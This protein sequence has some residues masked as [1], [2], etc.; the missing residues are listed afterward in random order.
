MD[1]QEDLRAAEC[2]RILFEVIDEGLAIRFA[3]HDCRN[4]NTSPSSVVGHLDFGN[5]FI[6]VVDDDRKLA[7]SP[8]NVSSFGN[9]RAFAS[10]N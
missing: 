9:E 5:V 7:S 6:F 4:A 8:R 10:L 2:G 3:D 1:I